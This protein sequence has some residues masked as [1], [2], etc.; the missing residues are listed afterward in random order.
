[1]VNSLEMYSNKK[2]TI[3]KYYKGWHEIQLQINGKKNKKQ[4]FFLSM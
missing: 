3:R 4:R 1:M 2:N